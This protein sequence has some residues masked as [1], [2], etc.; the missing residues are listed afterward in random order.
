MSRD[1]V[2]K[3][4]PEDKL[5]FQKCDICGD[6]YDMRSIDDLIVHGHPDLDVDLPQPRERKPKRA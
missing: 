1:E 5:H 6:H 2:A 3:L 4:S